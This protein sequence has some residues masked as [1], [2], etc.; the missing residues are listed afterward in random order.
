MN[1]LNSFSLIKLFF[2]KDKRC[3]S[4]IFNGVLGRNCI[5]NVGFYC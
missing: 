5:G 2:Y 4:Y 3:L 1:G